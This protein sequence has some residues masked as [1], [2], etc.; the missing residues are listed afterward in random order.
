MLNNKKD[1]LILI[2]AF[3]EDKTIQEVIKKLKNMVMY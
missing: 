3:N 2:P 1:L